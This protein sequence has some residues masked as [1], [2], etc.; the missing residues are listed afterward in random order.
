MNGEREGEES[1]SRGT[2]QAKCEKAKR[3]E[4]GISKIRKDKSVLAH[5]RE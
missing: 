3:I 4:F 2:W 5:Y 1:M